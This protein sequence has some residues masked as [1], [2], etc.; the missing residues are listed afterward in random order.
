[1]NVQTV[2]KLR[3]VQKLEAVFSVGYLSEETFRTI[4]AN[5]NKPKTN[6]L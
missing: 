4:A 5:G 3:P 6:P 2:E 1:M